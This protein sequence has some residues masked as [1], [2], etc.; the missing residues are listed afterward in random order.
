M[1][2]LFGKLMAS[3]ELDQCFAVRPQLLKQRINDFLGINNKIIQKPT[4]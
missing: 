4:Y 3:H 1:A 2:P